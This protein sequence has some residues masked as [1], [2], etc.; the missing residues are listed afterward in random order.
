MCKKYAYF[1]FMKEEPEKIG[2]IVPQHI[3]YWQELNIDGYQGGP[4]ADRSGGHITFTSDNIDQARDIVK[5]DPFY[6]E[7]LL[8][9]RWIKEWLVE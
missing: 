9:D 3:E 2:Q 5:K 8:A 6:R 4:F 7:D 1:Y